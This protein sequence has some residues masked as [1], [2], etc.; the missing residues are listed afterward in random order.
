MSNKQTSA[1]GSG[2]GSRKVQILEDDLQPSTS[3]GSY[4]AKDA[5]DV[6][7]SLIP[8]TQL[9]DQGTQELQEL[10]LSVFNQDA[11]EQGQW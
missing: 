10:G 7:T 4:K 3:S 2:S 6:D 8:Q 11:F 9:Q 1:S 5:F